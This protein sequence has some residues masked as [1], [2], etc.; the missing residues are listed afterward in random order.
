[1]TANSQPMTADEWYER[2]ILFSDRKNHRHAI[3]CYEK[4]IALNPDHPGAHYELGCEYSYIGEYNTSRRFLER[5][6]SLMT[7]SVA[8]HSFKVPIRST[9]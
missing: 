5:A 2:G 7:K 9:T 1:M 6:S 4:A 8:S 3:E